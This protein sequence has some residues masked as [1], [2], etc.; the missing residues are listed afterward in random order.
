[1]AC[2]N[3]KPAEEA[4]S[5]PVVEAEPVKE[6]VVE[7]NFKS[8]T[9]DEFK[10]MLNNV[11]VD[12]FQRKNI[13][14]LEKVIPTTSEESLSAN[15]GENYST[16]FQ[17]NLGNKTPKEVEFIS[18]T[19]KYGDRAIQIS[20]QNLNEYVAVNNKY[21]AYDSIS[22]ILKTSMVDGRHFPTVIMRKKT[23]RSLAEE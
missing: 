10:L 9:E 23:L 20:R 5:N 12:E 21:V 2:K 3:E 16:D 1:M 7:M 13:H 8:N 6:F 11:E 15:F 19:V 22:G 17:I 14:V 18:M 4:E